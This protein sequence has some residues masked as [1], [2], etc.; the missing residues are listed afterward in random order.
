LVPVL[1]KLEKEFA[2]KFIVVSNRE[3]AFHLNSLVYIHW[4][5]ATEIA[6]LLKFNIG[7]MPLTDDQWARGK[8]GFKALQYMA[9]GM[10]A[11]AS[12]VGVNIKIID[13][14][15]NGY[16]CESAEE[17]EEAI[18]QLLTEKQKRIE[19][20]REARKKIVDRYSVLAN[21]GN[22]LSLIT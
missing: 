15:L 17:W 16:L 20:G 2:F 18:R 10:P 9:L 7:L 13:N 14:N 11:I 1:S 21:R 6:D 4:Q 3:P 19:M 5:K 22:F 8:C 12:P